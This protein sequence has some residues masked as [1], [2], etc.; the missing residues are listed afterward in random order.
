M[1]LFL[2]VKPINTIFYIIINTLCMSL[3]LLVKPINTIFYNY[4]HSVYEF[5]LNQSI[6]YFI[7]CQSCGL[8]RTY[9]AK[10]SN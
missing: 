4:K 7:N 5:V 6:Q 10:T 2:L 8:C 1:S 3:F 9:N